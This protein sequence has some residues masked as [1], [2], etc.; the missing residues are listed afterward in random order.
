MKKY[1]PFMF[2][3]VLMV[4]TCEICIA[5]SPGIH[6]TPDNL[7]KQPLLFQIT[8]TAEGDRVRFRVTVERKKV[9]VPPK[10]DVRLNIVDGKALLVSCLVAESREKHVLSYE[11]LVAQ[12]YLTESMLIITDKENVPKSPEDGAYWFLLSD[13]ASSA[14][15]EK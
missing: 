13:F 14:N 5:D 10:V 4:G 6:L 2:A 9:N 12:K 8:A 7:K 1:L 15:P 11:F 3:A